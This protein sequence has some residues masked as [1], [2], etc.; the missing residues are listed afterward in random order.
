[1]M[2]LRLF[3]LRLSLLIV[4]G[5]VTSWI[6]PASSS[7]IFFSNL[8]KVCEKNNKK[9]LH[10]I[11]KR[12]ESESTTRHSS[13]PTV[14]NLLN[15]YAKSFLHKGDFENI[16]KLIELNQKYTVSLLQI[17]NEAELESVD[18]FVRFIYH[19]SDPGKFN[20]W[21]EAISPS[22]KTEA[23]KKAYIK[24]ILSLVFEN[25]TED[26]FVNLLLQDPAW[27]KALDDSSAKMIWQKIRFTPSLKS[28]LPP[29]IGTM[30]PD[31]LRTL[32][33]GLYFKIYSKDINKS[34]TTLEKGLETLEQGSSFK[35]GLSYEYLL[36]LAKLYK[37]QGK[38][39]KALA[40]LSKIE[41]SQ[42]TIDDY[43]LNYRVFFF[44][45]YLSSYSITL[46]KSSCEELVKLSPR[47]NETSHKVQLYLFLTKELLKEKKAIA[48]QP[49]EQYQR[50]WLIKDF[51]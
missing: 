50:T 47:E 33:S 7:E 27:K 41:R 36:E 13:I 38:T 12:M 19:F 45:C 1:M 17:S 30:Q 43:L 42:M 21:A 3:R 4:A 29:E 6:Y 34:V 32:Y 20:R 26:K 25:N 40:A 15:V 9:C 2:N 18:F 37:S 14:I 46:K 23:Q 51:I 31:A 11:L 5:I 16:N 49:A 39:E 44:E 35:K 22:M 48:P 10:I 24:Y 8:S 28:E